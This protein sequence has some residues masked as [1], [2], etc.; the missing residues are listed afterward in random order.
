M[1]YG[2]VGTAPFFLDSLN[3]LIACRLLLGVAEA[4]IL[5]IVNTLIADYWDDR[6]RKD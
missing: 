4:A 2:I 6:G 3:A 1:L 5:T